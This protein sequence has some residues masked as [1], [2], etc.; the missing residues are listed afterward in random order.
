MAVWKLGKEKAG[1]KFLPARTTT[2]AAENKPE[3]FI[4]NDNFF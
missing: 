1:R 2:V 4:I 3:R